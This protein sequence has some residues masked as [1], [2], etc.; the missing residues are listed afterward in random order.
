LEDGVI[1]PEAKLVAEPGIL[2]RIQ[3]IHRAWYRYKKLL[4]RII[5]QWGK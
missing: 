5:W 2:R 3:A 4:K 1:Y